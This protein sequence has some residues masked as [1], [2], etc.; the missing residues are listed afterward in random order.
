MTDKEARAI[1]ARI[2]PEFTPIMKK[3]VLFDY[4]LFAAQANFDAATIRL[5]LKKVKSEIAD[6]IYHGEPTENLLVRR[7]V[8]YLLAEDRGLL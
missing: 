8:L 6:A 5:E 3:K 1:K 4:P 2:N 7:E